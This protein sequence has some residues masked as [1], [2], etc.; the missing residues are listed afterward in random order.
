MMH[1]R[2]INRKE[3]EGKPA[4]SFFLNCL[5]VFYGAKKGFLAAAFFFLVP[6]SSYFGYRGL[7]HSWVEKRKRERER[8]RMWRILG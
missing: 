4:L 3:E 7:G 2:K 8:E 1:T 6:H 5:V